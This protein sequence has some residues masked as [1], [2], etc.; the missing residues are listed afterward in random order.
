[1]SELEMID[2]SVE[3]AHVWLNDMAEELGTDDRQFAYR[4]LR[5]S[6]HAIRDRLPVEE[7]AQLAAQMPLLIRGIYYENWRPAAT[8]M[9][10]RD[11]DSFLERVTE[12]GGSPARRRPPTRHRQRPVFSAATSPKAR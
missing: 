12:E 6:L 9:T 7:A 1:M 10:Y 11:I 8:P 2:R 5:A 4:A 3:K